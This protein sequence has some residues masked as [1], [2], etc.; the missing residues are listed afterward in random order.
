MNKKNKHIFMLFIL[1][2][3][4]TLSASAAPM[5]NS[6]L[7]DPIL[8]VVYLIAVVLLLIAYL[9]YL[10]SQKLK[11]F[12]NDES[13]VELYER[14]NFW[15]KLF[16]LKPTD[17][18]KDVMID[19]PHD[20]IYELDNPPPPWF[21]FLFYGTILFAVVYFVRFSVLKTGL[22]QEQE[23]ELAMQ[24]AQEAKASSSEDG[25]YDEIDENNVTVLLAAA[26]IDKGR[27]IYNQNCRVCHG[28]D[29]AGIDKSGPNLTDEF[30]LHGGGATNVYR[31][32]K[33]GVIEKGMRSWKDDLTPRMMQQVT[34]YIISL[35]GTNPEG[36]QPPQGEKW[37]EPASDAPTDATEDTEEE[38]TEEA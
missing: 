34:S 10:V 17:T 29:G 20:G 13:Q 9:L 33:Y 32:I 22:N 14:R 11:T 30:W 21:M 4:T 12:I 1:G 16:Q 28:K 25:D 37:V 18:D 15:E 2:A 27:S 8:W 36:A 19:E 5:L 31:T 23:Y 6:G 3:G 26:D 35:Q 38:T 7:N 24:L